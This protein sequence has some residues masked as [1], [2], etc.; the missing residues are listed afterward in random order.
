MCSVLIADDDINLAT[1]CRNFLTNEKN[2]E[3]VGIAHTGKEA[4]TAYIDTKPDVVLLDLKMPDMD[5]IEVINQL[6]NFR[7][8]KNKNNIIVIS[9][10]LGQIMPYNT[11]RIYRILPKPFDFNELVKSINEIQGIIDAEFLERKVDDLFLDL[12]LYFYS[13]K[14][15]EYLK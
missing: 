4:I 13:S 3:V 8:E 12:K 14:N 1:T 15:V 9:S 11:S 7:D 2:I 6:N 5:G 10:V